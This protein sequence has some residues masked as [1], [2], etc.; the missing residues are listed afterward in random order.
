MLYLIHKKY[1]VH[2]IPIHFPKNARFITP[3]G[4]ISNH[5]VFGRFII[6]PVTPELIPIS[7]PSNDPPLSNNDSVK[8]TLCTFT[9]YVNE[10]SPPVGSV[11]EKLYNTG[12]YFELLQYSLD[13]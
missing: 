10:L 6:L 8:L 11:A 2:I 3:L 13:Y 1:F 7:Y 12:L 9:Q 4:V 5:P